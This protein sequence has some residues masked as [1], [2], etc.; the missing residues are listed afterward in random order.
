ML[1]RADWWMHHPKIIRPLAV[2][3]LPGALQLGRYNQTVAHAALDEHRHEGAMEICLLLRGRQTY[4]VGGK[5]YEMRG[6]DV[7]LTFPGEV[8][9]TG[10]RPQEKGVLYWLILGLPTPGGA[11]PGPGGAE[12]ASA[13]R[14]LPRRHFAGDWRL[15]EHCDAIMRLEL[16]R[17]TTTR[18]AAIWHHVTGFLLVVVE[19]ARSGRERRRASSLQ[20]VVEHIERHLDQRLPLPELATVARL[21]VPRFKARF[22]EEHGMPPGEYVMRVR[23]ERAV[24]LLRTTPLP[25]TRIAHDLGFPSSQYFATVIKR[26]TRRTPREFRA[27][28]PAAAARNDR[29]GQ[30]GGA[31]GAA[32]TAARGPA[33]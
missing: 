7:F 31:P 15:R 24:E 3:G 1:R 32:A 17:K 18:A 20:P 6:G 11:L 14:R 8:H 2:P 16:G 12:L 21:S 22:S 28:V 23:V 4:V 26:Y 13:L 30:P 19:L 9:S 10:T 33:R 25:I 29:A 27:D 5:S